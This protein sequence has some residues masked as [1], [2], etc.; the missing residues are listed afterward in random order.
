MVEYPYGKKGWKVY[1]IETGDIFVSR[2]VIFHED[3]YPFVGS[4]KD[5]EYA[6][7]EQSGRWVS[8]GCFGHTLRTTA[9]R[10]QPTNTW[11]E[12]AAGPTYVCADKVALT[13]AEPLVTGEAHTRLEG[14]KSL[15]S[16][17]KH[18][19]R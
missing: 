15:A 10:S 9:E 8:D 4:D 14:D 6:N 17:G 1:D 18:P 5:Q 16:R 7:I 12:E 13:S 19:N 3:T 11:M 2:D